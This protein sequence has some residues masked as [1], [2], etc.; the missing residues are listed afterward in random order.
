MFDVGFQSKNKHRTVVKRFRCYSKRRNIFVQS[1]AAARKIIE[2]FKKEFIF[3]TDPLSRLK[4]ENI[5]LFFFF[6]VAKLFLYIY[7]ARSRHRTGD[8]DWIFIHIIY[9]IN[10]EIIMYTGFF[11]LVRTLSFYYM[12]RVYR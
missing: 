3:L 9:R 12:R 7:T 1:L 8:S 4:D 2:L 6:V 10:L 5:Y 11:F